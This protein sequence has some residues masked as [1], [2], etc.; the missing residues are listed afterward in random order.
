MKILYDCFSCS[1]YYG[2][3]EGIGWFWP[4]Y[5]RRYH[6]VWALVRN[7]RRPDIERYCK[8]H[9][10]E[11]I[12]FIYCDIPEW[13]NF[14]YMRKQQN[15]NGT[16]DFLAYQFL[17]QFPAYSAAKRVHKQVRFDIVHHVSTNDFRLIG[18]LYRLGVPYILGPIGGAQE[19]PEALRDYTCMYSKKER[20][21]TILN[22]LMTSLP[23]Y[24]KALNSAVKIYFSNPETEIYLA[25]KIKNFSKCSLL[26]EI[27][28]TEAQIVKIPQYHSKV[29]AAAMFLWAGRMEYRKGLELLFDALDILPKDLD[30][31]VVLCGDGTEREHYQ[32]LCAARSYDERVYFMGKL[33]Y[34][35]M[36]EMYNKADVFVFPSLR[37]TTGTVIVEAMAH[38]LPVICLKRGGA[39][40][41]V[42]DETGF[43]ISGDKREDYINNFADAMIQCIQNQNIVKVKGMASV[44]RIRAA[45]TW[46]QKVGAMANVY[47]DIL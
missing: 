19:T 5:M 10:I 21:R 23:G 24:K 40:L 12:H 34:E 41:V 44:E 13:M 45:Y 30:W 37:E 17:W 11:D 2:S 32:E 35:K 47:K 16:I 14:Y 15:K 3:D 31:Q 9:N 7:D 42:T 18:R 8:E 29:K 22:R 6:E 4:F 46:E 39:A 20:L 1:P 25:S 36:Q 28:Y 43:L 27:A 38:S 26:T 33:S